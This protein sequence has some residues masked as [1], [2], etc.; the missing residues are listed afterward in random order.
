M[1]VVHRPHFIRTRRKRQRHSR[2]GSNSLAPPTLHRQPFL[3]VQPIHSLVVDPPPKRS[4]LGLLPSQE[5]VQPPIAESWTIGCQL[6]QLSSQRDFVP[7]SS[8]VTPAPAVHPDQP[9]QARRS[10]SLASSRTT[11]TASRSARGPTTFLPAPPSARRGPAPAAPR[12]SSAVRSLPP[13]DAAAWS[14]SLPDPHTSP[15]SGRT[16]LH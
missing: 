15:S 9:P 16:W 6:A 2:F 10:L 1:R 13:A 7:F 8:L 14:R 4:V 5:N 3:P 11:R 12:S